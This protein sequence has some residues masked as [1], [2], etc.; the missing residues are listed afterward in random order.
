MG[1]KNLKRALSLLIA[2]T[3]AVGGF[4]LWRHEQAKVLDYHLLAAAKNGNV[5]TVAGLLRRGAR[6]NAKFG[7]NGETALH[8]ATAHGHSKIV[9]FLLEQGADVNA[10]DDVG[11][12]ALIS[13]SYHG[14][15]ETVRIL[16]NA[17]AD[18]N[19]K[20]TRH[21]FTALHEAARKGHLEIVKILVAKGADINIRTVDGR[22]AL[23]RAE[24]EGHI[25]I[26][27]VLRDAEKA[28]RAGLAK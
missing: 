25:E 21:N 6:V 27:K 23:A 16:L 3:L 19:A 8:R 26:A 5:E 28:T 4:F 1:Q 22:T 10:P 11:A 13:A 2:I 7:G 14:Y 12:T 24:A 20:D 17:G 18:V 15:T 9:K